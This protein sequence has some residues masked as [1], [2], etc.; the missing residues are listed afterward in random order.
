MTNIAH[1]EHFVYRCYDRG[2]RLL[3]IGCTQY[4]ER[5]IGEHR[6][7]SRW[8]GLLAT[9]TFEGPYGYYEGFAVERAAIEAEAPMFNR[10]GLVAS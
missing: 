2:G 10:A 6:K 8:G 3:Y 1:V 7:R 5:R 9:Q 4:P